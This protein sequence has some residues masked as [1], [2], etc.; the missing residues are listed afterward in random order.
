MFVI[1]EKDKN[2]CVNSGKTLKPWANGYPSIDGILAYPSELYSSFSVETL[3]EGEIK[4]YCYT[5]EMGFYENPNYVEPDPTNTYGIPDEVLAQI[6]Q[7]TLDSIVS[8][9]NA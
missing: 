6:R 7:D 5:E 9:V 2:V 1:V 8:E 3:P 4:K